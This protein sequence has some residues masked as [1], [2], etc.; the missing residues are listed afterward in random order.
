MNRNIETLASLVNQVNELETDYNFILTL[1]KSRFSLSVSVY[2]SVLSGHALMDL[3]E[4][5]AFMETGNAEERAL[6]HAIAILTNFMRYQEFTGIERL[7]LAQ[8]MV[9]DLE[10]KGKPH[11]EKEVYD[12]FQLDQT[13]GGV[14]NGHHKQI[15]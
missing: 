6:N 7:V 5:T 14:L 4:Y 12:F 8:K 10:T 3:V 11:M 13:V 2:H 1:D 15:G 9:E